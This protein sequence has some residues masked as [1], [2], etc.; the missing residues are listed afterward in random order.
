MRDLAG[1]TAAVL[2][3]GS[4]IGMGVALG[5]AAEGVNVMVADIEP[6]AA[7]AVSLRIQEGG[8]RARSLRTDGTDP[9]SLAEMVDCAV[10][11]FGG[12]HVLSNNVGVILDR[13]LDRCTRADWDWI[14]EFN[15]YSIV[16]GVEAV[17]PRLREQGEGGHIVNTASIAAVLAL[18]KSELIP[19]HIG[20]Y[21]ATKHAI[22]GYS[23]ILRGELA[24][25]GIGV[26]VLCP[27]RV[28]SNLSATAAR[29]RPE[30]HGGPLPAPPEPA[31][32]MQ[33]RIMP[34]E[35]VGPIVV[36][37][38]LADRLHIFTHPESV[39]MVEERQRRMLEDFAF[40]AEGG[41]G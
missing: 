23:E 21:T 26:S 29:N 4:G 18:P 35:Q 41:E 16:R 30:R 38:I 11:E 31:G 8:G 34:P 32:E 40:F 19:A 24:P 3:G 36:R 9:D 22:L 14:V 1:K 20:A 37:G 6:E 2:G 7:S 33:E 39:R 12:L 28:R 27:D 5:L 25:E 15:F 10:S 17:L 13:P